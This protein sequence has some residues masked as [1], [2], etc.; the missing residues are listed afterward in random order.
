MHY[1]V[2]Q[3]IQEGNEEQIRLFIPSQSDSGK[4]T[5]DAGLAAV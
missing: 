3:T 4:E 5:E 2:V 1:G